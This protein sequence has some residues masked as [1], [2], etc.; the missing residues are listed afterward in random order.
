MEKQNERKNSAQSSE[1]STDGISSNCNTEVLNFD[2]TN[3]PQR[4]IFQLRNSYLI[5]EGRDGILLIDQHRAHINI[6]YH[7][8]ISE[9]KTGK[10]STQALMFPSVLELDSD[11][12]VML[13]SVIETIERIGFTIGN[14]ASGNYVIEGIPGTL[15]ESDPAKTIVSILD[16]F[17]EKGD[18]IENEMMNRALLVAARASALKRG[19]ALNNLEIEHLASSL[20]RLSSPGF[21]PDGKTVIYRLTDQNLKTFFS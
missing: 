20:F 11:Q 2:E 9:I 10:V 17:A 8:L 1:Y 21:T 16:D 4:K 12:R 3:T 14:D 6:L 5:T 19:T 15:G 7:T 13:D 18:V